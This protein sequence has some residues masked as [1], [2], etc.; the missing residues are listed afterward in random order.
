MH[1]EFAMHAPPLTVA[2]YR[3]IPMTFAWAS[4]PP[5]SSPTST[6]VVVVVA[7]LLAVADDQISASFAVQ[8]G[9]TGAEGRPEQAANSSS[10]GDS[11]LQD[12]HSSPKVSVA[13]RTGKDVGGWGEGVK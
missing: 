1:V 4:S 13:L 3:Y 12:V 6:V 2:Q 9:P 8:A 5:P 11:A 7:L 10:Q